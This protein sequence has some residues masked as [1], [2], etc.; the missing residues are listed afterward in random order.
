[1]R[2]FKTLYNIISSKSF[3]ILIISGWGF[4]YVTGAIFLK[5]AFAF[6]IDGLRDN[7]FIYIPYLIFLM[8]GY[9]NLFRT[10]MDSLK[11]ERLRLIGKIL[12]FGVM[13]FLTG[14]FISAQLRTFDWIVTGEGDMIRLKWSGEEFLISKINLGIKEK[15]IDFEETKGVFA[16]EPKAMIMDRESR[17]LEIGAFP[18]RRSRGNYFH[19]LNCGLAPGIILKEGEKMI[20]EG[21]IPMRILPPGSNDFFEIPPYPYR[22][23]LSL[24][25]ERVIQK[26]ESKLSEYN[27]REP[28]Y[29]LR[30]MKGET[31]V[32]EGEAVREMDFDSLRI[33]FM[34][35]V[36]WIL[37]EVVNDPGLPLM[38]LGLLIS[39]AGFPSSLFYIFIRR[40][41]VIKS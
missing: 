10:I 20:T 40:R 11:G 36:P 8:S 26:G 15:F 24:S 1:M 6:F 12:P 31:V 37:L 22:F 19:I 7:P 32:A 35:P 3:L 14:F 18:P 9:A 2:V 23:L 25:P 28:R 38:V 16:F 13:V 5:E 29:R 4:F 34:T 17:M 39:V 30:V 41:K 27:L 21:Y 33:N